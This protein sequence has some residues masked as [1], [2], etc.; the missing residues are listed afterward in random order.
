MFYPK[1]E[2]LFIDC[3]FKTL[4]SVPEMRRNNSLRVVVIGGGIGGAELARNVASKEGL[5]LVLIEPKDQIECQALYPGYLCGQIKIDNTIAPLKPFCDQMGF[6]LVKDRAL[7]V[8]LGKKI[9][10]CTSNEVEYDLLVVTVGAVQNY[11]GI[12][13]AENTFSINTFDETIRA[14]EFVE[15]KSPENIVIVGSGLV[16][17]E[18]AGALIESFDATIHIAEMMDRLLPAFP[19]ST[20]ALI[21]KILEKKGVKIFTSKQVK[22]IRKDR[23]IFSDGNYLKCLMTIWAA[24]IQ[25][26]HFVKNLDLPKKKGWLLTDSYQRVQNQEDVFAI[27]DNAWVEIEGKLATKTGLEAERQAKQTAKNLARLAKGKKLVPYSVKASADRQI[28][29]I[30]TGCGCAVGVYRNLTISVPSKLIYALKS[31]IDKSFIKRFK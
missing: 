15:T 7:S 18:I 16:G 23:V 17:V 1:T 2:Y 12:E 31:W 14:K 8:D 10:T 30:S 6:E 11:Y 19:Q 27:G 22:E 5:D 25:P 21:K 26:S 20:S 9:V 28:A 29:I 24:G 13:G 3:A 4:K